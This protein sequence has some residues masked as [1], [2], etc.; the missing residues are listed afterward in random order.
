[1]RSYICLASQHHVIN[2]RW[3]GLKP[4]ATFETSNSIYGWSG[5]KR[6][7]T[8]AEAEAW[9]FFVYTKSPDEFENIDLIVVRISHKLGR[10][11]L[12]PCRDV[13]VRRT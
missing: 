11:I 6:F 3:L 9:R 13:A 4:D 12:R 8:K 7:R 2:G 1:M 10:M 5:V